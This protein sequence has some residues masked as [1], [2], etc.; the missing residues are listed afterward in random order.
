MAAVDGGDNYW[1]ARAD[2]SDLGALVTEH[3]LPLLAD[4]QAI[5]T[6]RIGLLGGSIGRVRGTAPHRVA[7]AS[8]CGG[9]RGGVPGPVVQR[10]RDP[11]RRFDDAEY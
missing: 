6:T 5:D 11:G 7:G 4:E 1:Q 10:G 2:G 9:S 8:A 3:L